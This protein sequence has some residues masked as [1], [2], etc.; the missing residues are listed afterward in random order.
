MAKAAPARRRPIAPPPPGAT[1]LAAEVGERALGLALLPDG[2]LQASMLDADRRGVDGLAVSFAGG[3]RTIAATPCGPGCYR[4]T[5]GVAGSRV[6]VLV[7]GRRVASF[8]LPATTRPAGALV[9]RARAA[10][11]RLRSVVIDERLASSPRDS[12]RTIW[13]LAAPDRLAYD[14]SSGA[15]A[16]V[17]GAKRWDRNGK[18]P[19][20]ASPQTPLRTPS[21]WWGPQPL[22]AR[23]IGS[24]TVGGRPALVTTFFD[25]GLP[26]WFEVAIARRSGLPLTLAMTTGAHFMHHRYSGFDAPIRIRPPTS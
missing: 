11:V 7:G 12:I 2:R 6:G 18:G 20:V 10:F 5:E 15:S 22:D 1:V 13:R 8:R 4:S 17:I 19:W 26:A 24:T 3:G 9:R 25:P 23:V 14:S 16:V 21:P